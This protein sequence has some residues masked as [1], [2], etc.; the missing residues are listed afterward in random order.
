MCAT[1][2]SYDVRYISGWVL[3]LKVRNKDLGRV[4]VPERE[5]EK[6]GRRH[7]GVRFGTLPDSKVNAQCSAISVL[8]KS[9]YLQQRVRYV[10]IRC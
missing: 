2:Y 9:F 7:S 8:I 1:L 4:H 3:S 10:S 5:Q 6:I